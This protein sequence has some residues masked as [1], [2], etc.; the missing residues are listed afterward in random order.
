LGLAFRSCPC[1]RRGLGFAGVCS[2]FLL[3]FGCA[4]GA[5]WRHGPGGGAG[6]SR[7]LGRVLGKGGAAAWVARRRLRVLG[8]EIYEQDGNNGDINFQF[9]GSYAGTT[10]IM[11]EDAQLTSGPHQVEFGIHGNTG[12]STSYNIAYQA[13]GTT[14]PVGLPMSILSLASS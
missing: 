13:S 6:G 9:L 8:G 5:A 14:P 10:P 1:E 4:G 12:Q 7:R 3:A 11:C 2:A